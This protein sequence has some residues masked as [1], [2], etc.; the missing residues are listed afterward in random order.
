MK[1][2]FED[3]KIMTRSESLTVFNAAWVELWSSV[4]C[5]LYR[6]EPGKKSLNVSFVLLYRRLDRKGAYRPEG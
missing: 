6:L 1:A 4:L 3:Q 2:I 5:R